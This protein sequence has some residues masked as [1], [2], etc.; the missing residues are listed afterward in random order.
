MEKG[1]GLTPDHKHPADILALPLMLPSHPLCL[2]LGKQ[3]S[4]QRRE[5]T[6]PMTPSALS[7]GG[8]VSHSRAPWRHGNWGKEAHT[9]CLA[10]CITTTSSCHKSQAL[11]EIYSR[12]SSELLLGPFWVGRC[13][14]GGVHGVIV[15][16]LL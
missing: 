11:A 9:T 16:M 3:H 12:P 15:L 6:E 14:P 13:L 7:W 10:S 2:S 5:N 1:S 4:R 8:F